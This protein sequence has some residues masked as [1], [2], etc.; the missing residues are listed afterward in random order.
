MQHLRLRE[1]VRLAAAFVGGAQPAACPATEG[2]G[3]AGCGQRRLGDYDPALRAVLRGRADMLTRD[4][5]KTLV[6]IDGISPFSGVGEPDPEMQRYADSERVNWACPD[7]RAQ[8]PG[9]AAGARR[10]PSI[11]SSTTARR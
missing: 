11:S 10:M 2:S 7:R 6:P 5:F 1:S 9:G 3:T 8:G 4:G